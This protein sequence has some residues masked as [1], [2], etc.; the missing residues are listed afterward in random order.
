MNARA[1]TG[2]RMGITL[3]TALLSW[4]ITLVTLLMFVAVILPQQKAT[5]LENL[6]SKAYGVMVSVR[7]VGVGALVNKDFTT[8]VEHCKGILKDDPSVLYL[9]V[10]KSEDG[11]SLLHE[12]D[13]S[14]TREGVRWSDATLPR[15]WRPAQRTPTGGIR[16]APPFKRRVFLFSHP[17]NY[18]GIEWGW[19]H[20]GL[21]LESYDRSMSAVHK[22]TALLAILCLLLGLVASILYAKRIV[23]PILSLRTAVQQVAGGDLSARAEVTRSDELGTLAVSVNT[24]TEA[25]LRRDRILESVRFAA[26]EFVGAQ[27]WRGV[28]HGVLLKLGQAAAASRAYVVESC[29]DSTGAAAASR[30]HEWA[31]PHAPTHPRLPDVAR[32]GGATAWHDRWNGLFGKDASV[33]G[34]TSRLPDDKRAFLE[35]RSVRSILTIPI[36]VEGQWWG[37]LGLDDC[38]SD[39][40]WTEAEQDSL[41]AAADMLGATVARQRAQDALVQAK[42]EL[43][44]RVRE[45]TREL[46][47]QVRAKEQ[48]LLE[49]ERAEAELAKLN[50]ELQESARRA[51][52]AEVATGVLHNV[53]NVLNSVNVSC[54]LVLD[55]VKQSEVRQLSNLADLLNAQGDR[56][57]DFMA[58]DPRGIS[59]PTYLHTLAQVLTEERDLLLKEL[60]ALGERVDHIKQIVAMQQDSARVSGIFDTFA[61]TQ[62]VEDALRLN[63]GPLARHGVNVERRYKEVPQITTDK[64]RVLQILL[65]LVRNANI[66]CM[67]GAQTPKLLTLRV[68]APEPDRVEVQVTDNG[69][70]IPAENLLRIF[71]HGFTTRKS[72][73]G[74]GLHSGAIAARELGGSLT[75]QSAGSQQGATFTLSLPIRSPSHPI[76]P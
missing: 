7:D 48:A 19:I 41:R 52:M 71:A 58:T 67:E 23:R 4:L 20:V 26:Q 33:S 18:Q 27:D 28:I 32:A 5:F 61:V 56:L 11:F 8:V 44:V 66:A 72:G 74:F 54:T 53:G 10:T 16:I 21:S 13:S 35:A 9:V 68:H 43:E 63:A 62:L 15:D 70:G 34:P 45:R 24:M 38:L 6:R 17:C 1:P 22:R 75:A 30:L 51:G 76:H 36:Q 12:R 2:Q 49:R 25:L 57:T 64:H 47:E 73:H 3:R 14:N 65:N 40:I 29:L 42:A 50:Q 46:L 31:A 39:R 59:I 55:R 37:F 60:S 69:L